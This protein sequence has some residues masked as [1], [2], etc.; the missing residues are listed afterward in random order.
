[1]ATT[2]SLVT[3][4][5]GQAWIRGT[6]GSLTPIHQG[7]RIPADADVVTATGSSI[8][9]QADGLPPMTIGEN[10]D[11]QLSAE[12][13]QPNV[14]PS[15]AA[16]A[17]PADADTAQILAALSDGGDPFANLDPTAAV[18]QG[19]AGGD[20]GSSFTRLASIIETTTP[21]G[22][23][24]PRPTFPTVEEVRLGG[25]GSGGDDTAVTGTPGLPTL[26]IADLNAIE[27]G[28]LTVAENASAAKQ[29]TFQ[30]SA[31]AGLA[32][33]TVGGTQVTLDQLNAL[34]GSSTNAITITTENG[35]I[36]LTGYDPVG[37]TVTY[38]YQPNGPQDHTA[39]DNSV[40]DDITIIVTDG[41]GGQVTGNLGVHIT[42][43][44]PEAVGEA[45]T[46]TED[47]GSYI[48]SGNALDGDT[49]FD[50]ADGKALFGNWAADNAAQ[51]GTF[52]QNPDGTYTYELDNDNPAVNALND[53]ETLTETFTYTVKDSDGDTATATVTITINGRTDG[54][55]VVTPEP[56]PEP[57]VVVVEDKNGEATG[58]NQISEAA[59]DP[60]DGLITLVSVAG[61]ASVIIGGTI[62]S[63]AQLGAL[64]TTPV[65]I[66][67]AKGILTLTG[68]DAASGKLTYEYKVK[69]AQDHSAGDDTVVDTLPI[70]VTDGNGKSGTGILNVLITDTNPV[71][72]GET[73]IIVEDSGSY[74]VGGNA[75]DNDS[76]FDGPVAFGSWTSAPTAQ[77]GTV[78]L[79]ANGTYSYVLHNDNPA[80][81]ALNAGQSLQETFTYTV[82]DSDG[83]T[84][85][86]TVTITI[87]GR[88]DGPPTVSVPD[89]NGAAAGQVSIAEDATIAVSGHITVASE[90]G[91][92][93]VTVGGT[94][95]S[96]AQ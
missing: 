57:P 34:D 45:H 44:N 51:Y 74:T 66:P 94:A 72:V 4:I 92:A 38:E 85:T 79:N 70:T 88:T 2:T 9:L 10:R 93:S 83:D 15:T 22:L 24:Y 26:S 31:P 52:T 13:A 80:V 91:L 23:E 41:S 73:H 55:P 16:A 17:A 59:I 47:S 3:Q 62:V 69:G 76:A 32:F 27:P 61:V 42:D 67:T 29:G 81:N 5:T 35:S 39:G 28:Q 58:D 71:A 87:N 95:V 53:G 46:L 65:S 37:G 89:G 90:A 1:M 8:Q 77:Y 64:G 84:S 20:G 96:L 63:A 25:T 6:D 36:T 82:K 86:A 43:T 11:V 7:M 50:S 14:D 12:T 18:I 21:L 60:V 75:L 68:F 48:V 40:Q 56:E 33:I 54:P 49:A 78:T 19:G 30:F